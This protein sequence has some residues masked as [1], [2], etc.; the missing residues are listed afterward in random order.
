MF[1]TGMIKATTNK[2]AVVN[3]VTI[4]FDEDAQRVC[5]IRKLGDGEGSGAATPLRILTT[6]L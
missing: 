6:K 2:D 3:K 1:R 5:G 4:V